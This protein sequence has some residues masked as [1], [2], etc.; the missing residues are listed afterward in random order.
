MTREE[1]YDR[2]RTLSEDESVTKILEQLLFP[3]YKDNWRLI[4]NDQRL[5]AA[6]QEVLNVKTIE[7][8]R[9][10]LHILRSKLDEYPEYIELFGGEKN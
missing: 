4:V 5:R 7:E 9:A 6:L 2:K 3:Q 1:F 8:S 10:R